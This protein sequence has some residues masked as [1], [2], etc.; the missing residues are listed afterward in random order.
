[1]GVRDFKPF[2]RMARPILSKR[3]YTAA[4]KLLRIRAMTFSVVLEA[5]RLEALIRELTYYEDRC[6]EADAGWAIG[7]AECTLLPALE[8]GAAPHR[9][10]SD[11]TH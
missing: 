1:M 7:W 6:A 5:E 2:A 10:W 3:D 9:R 8:D 11:G 4:K